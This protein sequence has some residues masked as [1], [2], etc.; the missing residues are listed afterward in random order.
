MSLQT[1]LDS[2]FLSLQGG[3]SDQYNS[4][5]HRCLPEFHPVRPLF[6]TSLPD[7]L[8]LKKIQ[9]PPTT[10][11]KHPLQGFFRQLQR[12]SL[13]SFHLSI[14]QPASSPTSSHNCTQ[15][16][17]SSPS[18]NID[19]PLHNTITLNVPSPKGTVSGGTETREYTYRFHKA[20][21][22]FVLGATPASYL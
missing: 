15:D 16:R 21:Y 20:L 9:V 11:L 13:P 3:S 6:L 7:L 22:T 8:F 2:C 12:N 1:G 5:H 4:E 18:T 10:G 19:G 17:L 14:Q